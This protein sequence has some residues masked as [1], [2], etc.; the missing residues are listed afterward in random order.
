MK[1]FK[2]FIKDYRGQEILDTCNGLDCS[3]REV[4]NCIKNAYKQ[5]VKEFKNLV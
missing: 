3:L 4:I 5:Y 2:R 1:S